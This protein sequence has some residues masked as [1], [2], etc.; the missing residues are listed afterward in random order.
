MKLKVYEDSKNYTC[1]VVKL[2]SLQDVQGL[3][4]L[5]ST[6]VF[7]NQ[8]LVSKDTNL[9]DLYLYFPA[10]TKLSEQ[11]CRENNLYRHENLNKDENEKGF[12]EDSGRVKTLKFK[13]VISTCFIIPLSALYKV[14]GTSFILFEGNEF[15]SISDI[16]IC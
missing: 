5:K 9:E 3:D 1:T 11:F 6:T 16:E 4:N 13:G 12:F 8:C 7:G 10:E 2:N 14:I 15:N